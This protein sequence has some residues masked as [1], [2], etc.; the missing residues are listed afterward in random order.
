[1]TKTFST[2]GNWGT[3]IC[4]AETGEVIEYQRD[5]DWEKPGDGYDDITRLDADEWRA[6]YPQG[7]IAAGHDILDFGSWDKAGV[8]V[9]AESD[10]RFNLWL[11]RE[12]DTDETWRIVP[13]LGDKARAE[14]VEWLKSLP[15]DHYIS[16]KVA[17]ERWAQ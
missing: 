10:W 14:F 13:R 4:N 16:P 17:L 12:N 7:D 5:G 8:Y 15:A 9:P 3:L 1:M 2:G 11:D 6:T